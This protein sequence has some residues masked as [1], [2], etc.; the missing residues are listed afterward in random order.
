MPNDRTLTG[1]TPRRRAARANLTAAHA[2]PVDRASTAL[3]TWT[4]SLVTG[5]LS[6]AQRER[7]A[8][9]HG[10]PLDASPD[11]RVSYST[12]VAVWAELTANHP[13]P[14]LGVHLAAQLEPSTLGIVGYLGALSATFDE[15]LNRSVRFHRLLKDPSQN[16]LVRTRS[17]VTVI[18]EPPAGSPPWPRHLAEAT[19]AAYLEL[20]SRWTGQRLVP[21]RVT[22][23]HEAPQKPHLVREA[24]GAPVS[25]GERLNALT[26]PAATLAL[27]LLTHEPSLGRYLIDEAGRQLEPLQR[28]EGVLL[29]S[30]RHWIEKRLPE[31]PVTLALAARFLASSPR[32]L[33][34]ALAARGR[35][36]AD[37]VDEVRCAVAARLSADPTLT[38]SEIAFVLGFADV[39]GLRRAEARWRPFAGDETKRARSK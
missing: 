25:F 36:F 16:A 39:G 38:R 12:C 6:G 13:D 28:S 14:L 29:D 34:R 26:L 2:S 35:S 3:S 15:A 22:F 18:D 4:R 24:F 32:T 8:T 21:L 30:L 1:A 20:G 31:A 33:Q 7:F 17:T 19:L 37:V 11:S 27:P 23:Q 9:R 10:F 5:L